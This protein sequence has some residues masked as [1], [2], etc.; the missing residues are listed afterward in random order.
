[1]SASTLDSATLQALQNAGVFFATDLPGGS[2]TWLKPAELQALVADPEQFWREAGHDEAS[3]RKW[4]EDLA[5]LRAR[6][7]VSRRGRGKRS[8]AGRQGGPLAKV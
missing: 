6:G 4:M 8:P 5:A 1:M 2:M 3:I 7:F